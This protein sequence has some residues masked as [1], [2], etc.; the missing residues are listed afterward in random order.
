MEENNGKTTKKQE[1]EPI[2]VNGQLAFTI[3]KAR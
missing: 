2:L 3:R 1:I